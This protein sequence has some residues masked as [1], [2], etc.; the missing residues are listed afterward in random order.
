VNAPFHVQDVQVEGGENHF[1]SMLKNIDTHGKQ[2]F[3]PSQHS[4][5]QDCLGDNYVSK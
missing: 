3:T 2:D 4:F 1:T 5:M